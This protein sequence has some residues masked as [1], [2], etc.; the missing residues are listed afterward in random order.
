MKMKAPKI[1]RGSKAKRLPQKWYAE[2]KLV[3]EAV[4]IHEPFDWLKHK[5]KKG[6]YTFVQ[7]GFPEKEYLFP[8]NLYE[9][10]KMKK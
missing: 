9:A 7:T 6:T 8:F 2:H 1:I 5:K 10:R 3:D 4:S